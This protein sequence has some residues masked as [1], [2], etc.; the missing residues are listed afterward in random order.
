MLLPFSFEACESTCGEDQL[1]CHENPN[2][3]G[4]LGILILAQPTPSTPQLPLC[5]CFHMQDVQQYNNL[6]KYQ[7]FD[8][9]ENESNKRKKATRACLHCQ[10]VRQCNRTHICSIPFG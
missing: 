4:A 5:L 2:S 7:Q 1:L 6:L 8:S 3:A 10:K 9:A